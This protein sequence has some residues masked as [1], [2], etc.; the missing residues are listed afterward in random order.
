MNYDTHKQGTYMRA[1]A[2]TALAAHTSTQHVT[3]GVAPY[4]RDA[5]HG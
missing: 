2:T 3:H 5:G 1:H 4:R